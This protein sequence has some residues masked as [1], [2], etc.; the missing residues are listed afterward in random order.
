MLRQQEM[1][2]YTHEELGDIILLCPPNYKGNQTVV[3]LS[4]KDLPLMLRQQEMVIYT[5]EEQQEMVIY[6]HE[7]LG[8]IILLCPPD[9]KGN[10]TVVDLSQKDLPLMLRQQEMVIYTHEELGD[11]IL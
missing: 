6:T 8:D 9:Y 10:Q 1:V 5:H 2:I 4:Q 11:I 3:D 7:E